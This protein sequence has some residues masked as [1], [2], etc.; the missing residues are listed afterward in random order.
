MLADSSACFYDLCAAAAR[1]PVYARLQASDNSEA[2]AGPL[3]WFSRK[4]AKIKSAVCKK[5]AVFDGSERDGA[6]QRGPRPA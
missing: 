2:R 5:A 4:E 1:Q 6:L 3:H